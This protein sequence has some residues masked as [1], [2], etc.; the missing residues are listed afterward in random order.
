MTQPDKSTPYVLLDQ[1]T[2]TQ[3]KHSAETA[4][5]KRA[6]VCLHQHHEDKIQEMVI[7]LCRGTKV[8]VHRHPGRSES[9]HVVEGILEVLFFDDAGKEL[10][11]LVLGEPSSGY[12]FL[13][14]L[15]TSLWHSVVPVTEIAIV[16]ETVAGPFS[17]ESSEFLSC[18]E[19]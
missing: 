4:P 6:R 12:P 15:N 8:R 1:E 10:E 11:R 5:I 13:Y 9:F 2:I 18:I 17:T 19:P 7:A 3:L 16:H 14:R